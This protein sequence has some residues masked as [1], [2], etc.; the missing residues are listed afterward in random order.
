MTMLTGEMKESDIL[1][2]SIRLQVTQLLTRHFIFRD[3]SGGQF[4]GS[5]AN[6][7]INDVSRYKLIYSN[8]F[9]TCVTFQTKLPSNILYFL[10]E[11]KFFLEFVVWSKPK[12]SYLL[13][14][15]F[16]LEIARTPLFEPPTIEMPHNL[17]ARKQPRGLMQGIPWTGNIMKWVWWQ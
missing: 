1:W 14:M 17:R 11:S 4:V 13:T 5:G 10:L 3:F 2:I 8:L 7:H 12:C 6:S 15:N 9:R 16:N